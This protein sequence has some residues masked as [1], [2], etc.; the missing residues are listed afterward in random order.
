MGYGYPKQEHRETP[1]DTWGVLREEGR[2]YQPGDDFRT[3]ALAIGRLYRDFPFLQCMKKAAVLTHV[4]AGEAS[5]GVRSGLAIDMS[6]YAGEI[7]AT[8]CTLRPLPRLN[9]QAVLRFDLLGGYGYGDT[10]YDSDNTELTATSDSL[11]AFVE[12]D[13]HDDLLSYDEPVQEL[14]FVTAERM[15]HDYD[16]VIGQN[17]ENRFLAGFLWAKAAVDDLSTET[18]YPRLQVPGI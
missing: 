17:Y 18:D 9:R 15:F 11:G 5:G 4:A 12:G 8:H 13:W 10:T 7:L 14:L 6:F 2:L 1:K 16:R 3:G